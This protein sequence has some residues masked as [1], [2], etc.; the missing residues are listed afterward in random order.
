MEKKASA[1]TSV[2][3]FLSTLLHG[4]VIALIALGPAFI[5]GLNGKGDREATSVEFNVTDS[6]PATPADIR[7]VQQPVPQ[8][9]PAVAMPQ[10]Q[11]AVT[12]VQPV[13]AEVIQPQTKPIAKVKPDKTQ[14]MKT[15]KTATVIPTQLPEK[16]ESQQENEPVIEPQPIVAAREDDAIQE[17]SVIPPQEPEP[18][19]VVQ[20]AEPVVQ[21]AEPVHQQAEPIT[22]QPEPTITQQPEPPLDQPQIFPPVDESAKKQNEIAAAPSEKQNDLTAESAGGAQAQTQTSSAPSTGAQTQIA[23]TQNYTGLKQ[24]AG[25]QPPSYSR[26]M[27]IKKLQGRGQL[28]YYVTKEG[29]VSKLQLTRSTGSDALD[30]AAVEAFSKYRFVPGQEGYTL[31]D[32]EFSLKGPAESDSGR[33]RTTM[34]R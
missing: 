4:S 11:P 27:R 9:Q 34:A 28:I 16:I 29:R 30:R 32:F 6:T 31:H 2:S 12:P 18:K 20:Q 13:P 24:L 19:S 7:T 15:Q 25:N 26:E 8:P 23:V 3:L 10:A 22:Q 14:K 21:Q 33:L 17:T 1:R 5:P